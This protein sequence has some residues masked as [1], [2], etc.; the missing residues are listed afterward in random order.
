MNID[1]YMNLAIKKAEEALNYDEVP[2]GAVLINENN[3]QIISSRHNEITA[4][5]NPL[6]HAEMLVIEDAFK[7][8]KTKFLENTVI[9][10][11]LE[12]CFLCASAISEARIKKIYFGAY[13]EKKGALENNTKIFNNNKYYKPQVYGGINEEKC[14]MLLKEFFIKKRNLN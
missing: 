6:K 14:S 5:N 4:Q 1:F 10:S 3:N 12:P 9:F 11:T 13:D 8:I 2:V 7:I